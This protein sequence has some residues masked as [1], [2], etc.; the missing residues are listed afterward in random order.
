[1]FEEKAKIVAASPAD[2]MDKRWPFS[3]LISDKEILET[4]AKT[5]ANVRFFFF[6]G[7]NSEF[8]GPVTLI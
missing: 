6:S 4:A 8:Q 5:C 3:K 1:M 2:D 7:T